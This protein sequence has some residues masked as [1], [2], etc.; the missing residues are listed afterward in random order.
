MISS[1]I[2]AELADWIGRKTVLIGYLIISMA[3]VAIE[4]VAT[5]N[6]V[7][8][9]GKLLNGVMVGGVATTMLSYIGEVRYGR[10]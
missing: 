10:S 5:S 1:L 2:S 9:L 8:F 6:L 7:F 4:F 3:A